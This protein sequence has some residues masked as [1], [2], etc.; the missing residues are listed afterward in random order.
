MYVDGVD[1][2]P[3][4]GNSLVYTFDDA[5]APETH[6]T[7]YF[8]I[9]ANRGIYKD[10]WFARVIHKEPWTAKPIRSLQEDIWELYDTNADF[11]LSTDIVAQNPDKLEELKALF[12]QVASKNHALPLDD[13]GL[14]RLNPAIA[15]RP[16]LMGGRTSL[17]LA[18]GMKDLSENAF[19][20]IK[21][22]SKSIVAEVDVPQGGGD[23]VIIAQ[24]GRFG[25]WSF[26]LD[27]G[28]PTYTYNYL[29]QERTTIAADK[30]LPEGR[31]KVRM[32]FAYDGD[33]V[34]K[35]GLATP[36]LGDDEIANGRIEKTQPAIFSADETA[37]VGVDEATPVVGAYADNRGQFTGRVISVTVSIPKS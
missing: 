12:M 21:N 27:E 20:N 1:Q 22:K 31:S 37:D 6:T 28:K 11:S 4:Q 18:H 30:A 7:Q 5:N 16:D 14:K 8:E 2:V 23:G 19:I 36:F 29:G 17:T 15:G 35:G 25:G 10:G 13:R 9:F 32:D 24:G 26:Y 34:G 3:I 33:G